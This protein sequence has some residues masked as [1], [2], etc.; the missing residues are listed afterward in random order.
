[1]QFYI[2]VHKYAITKLK[3]AIKFKSVKLSLAH[4]LELLDP[5]FKIS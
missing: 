5:D 4:D 1:M 2:Y 3:V